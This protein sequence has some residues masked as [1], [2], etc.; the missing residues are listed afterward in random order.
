MRVVTLL[1]AATENVAALGGAGSLAGI[2]HACDHPLSL[3]HLPRV[4]ST[5]KCDGRAFT[6]RPGP[7]LADGAERLRIALTVGDGEDH[8]G[9]ARWR[10]CA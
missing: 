5:S 10:P 9:P 4:T 3:L 8:V 7:R 6:S 2:S 1:P